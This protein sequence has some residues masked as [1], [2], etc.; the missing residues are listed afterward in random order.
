MSVVLLDPRFPAMLPVEA[1]PLLGDD[2]C[3]TEEVPVRIRWVIADLGGHTVDDTEV[4]VTTD[5]ANEAVMERLERGDKLVKAPSLLMEMAGDREIEAASD[6]ALTATTGQ[7]P[8]AVDYSGGGVVDGEIVGTDDHTAAVA[9]LRRTSRTEVPSS[10]MDEVEDAVAL[11]TRAMRQG[12][13][14]QSQTH[15][16]LLAYLREETE[17]LAEVIDQVG[18][19]EDESGI[20]QQELCTELS[21]ILLQVLFHAEIANRRGAFDIG[22]VAGAFVAKMRSRAPYLFEDVERPVSRDEQDR[23]WAEGRVSEGKPAHKE[24]ATHRE[25]PHATTFAAVTN[26]TETPSAPSAPSA[27]AAAE[28]VIILARRNGLHDS[29]IPTDIRFPMIGLER[30]NVGD[31]DNR[32]ITAVETFRRELE[33]RFGDSSDSWGK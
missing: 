26:P 12:E 8:A 33:H 6:P 3:Y 16:S 19:G 15:H 9:G 20:D 32:L 1:V 28:E 5:L 27:L 18:P 21:D 7:Q 30:D 11:M 29:E 31:S 23:L 17:E 25:E 24:E 14:E 2:V 22:H 13:W 10:V 4:I